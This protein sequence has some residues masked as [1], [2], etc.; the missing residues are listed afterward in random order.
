M[1]RAIAVSPVG[2]WD[3]SKAVDS[4][5]LDYE[6]RHRRRILLTTEGGREVLLD[7]A[8]AALLKDGDGLLLEGGGILRIVARP[9][10]LAEIHAHDEGELVRIAW[11]LGN[12]HAPVELMGDRLRILED[13]VLAEMVR[14]LGGML[15]LLEAPF[16]P[17]RGAYGATE[18]EH[19]HE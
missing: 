9:E 12:R 11:H 5:V 17:E 15:R 1:T 2:L 18:R 10:A 19:R 7:L 13:H 3:I 14:G 8:R 4:V 16:T 6:Q